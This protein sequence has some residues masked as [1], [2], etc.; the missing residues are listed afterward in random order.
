ML[1]SINR[2]KGFTLLE[3]II[4]IFVVT[5]GL[6]GVYIITSQIISYITLSSSRLI[7]SYLAQEGIEIVRNV[8]DTNY[9]KEIAWDD[10]LANCSAGCEADYNDTAFSSFG[11]GRFFK[12]DNNGFYN[13][14]DG[15]NTTK[16]KRKI[17]ITNDTTSEGDEILKV[18]ATVTG[19]GKQRVEISV[20]ENLYNW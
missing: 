19:E 16:F 14:S 8:K 3:L 11:A 5:I 4:T 6:V 7:A 12:I 10:G 2:N 9:L 13:Y 1:Q 20:Q 17:T 18:V 15:A